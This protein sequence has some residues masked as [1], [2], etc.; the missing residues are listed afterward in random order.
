MITYHLTSII[1]YGR[2]LDG[3]GHYTHVMLNWTREKIIW[4]SKENQKRLG[5]KKKEE[6]KAEAARLKAEK[7]AQKERAKESKR[8]AAEKKPAKKDKKK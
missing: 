1:Q 3:L 7:A 2:D 6:E 4:E 5:K 8:N